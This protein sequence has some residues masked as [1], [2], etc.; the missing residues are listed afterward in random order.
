MSDTEKLKA[1]GIAK[2]LKPGEIPKRGRIGK[3]EGVLE[4]ALS[5]LDYDES[6]LLCSNDILYWRRISNSLYVIQ[7]TKK[8]FASLKIS[9][10]YDPDL[11]TFGIY[12]LKRDPSKKPKI[13]S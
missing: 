2:K 10:R 13:T 4:Y 6:F 11:K 8:K 1:L 7:K 9:R 12:V 5:H 3:Y